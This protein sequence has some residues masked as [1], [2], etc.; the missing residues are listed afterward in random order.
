MEWSET[1]IAFVWIMDLSVTEMTW[2]S[3]RRPSKLNSATT[4]LDFWGLYGKMGVARSVLHKIPLVC[5]V[6]GIVV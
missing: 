6:I 5:I 4:R 2:N 3:P 1:V